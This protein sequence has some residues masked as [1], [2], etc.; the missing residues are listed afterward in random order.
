MIT[1]TILIP[2]ASNEGAMFAPTHHTAFELYLAEVFGGVTRLPGEFW[3]AWIDAGTLYGDAT[4]AYQIAVSGLVE[5][6]AAVHAAAEH[7]AAHYRQE[8]IYV[9][10]LGQAEIIPARKG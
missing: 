10:Y 3:G 4:R 7:A 5:R 8:A 6:G 2:L 9:S 1:V